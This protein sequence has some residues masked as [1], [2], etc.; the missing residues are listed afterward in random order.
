MLIRSRSSLPTGLPH[1]VD[2]GETNTTLGTL[3]TITRRLKFKRSKMLAG[4][5]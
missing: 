1:F 4:V 5:D 3:A 2:G